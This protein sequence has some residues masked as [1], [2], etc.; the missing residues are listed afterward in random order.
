MPKLFTDVYQDL[1]YVSGCPSQLF[2]TIFKGNRSSKHF[3]V[4]NAI[5]KLEVLQDIGYVAGLLSQLVRP[6]FKVKEASKGAYPYFDEFSYRAPKNAYLK[7]QRFSCAITHHFFGDLD[8]DVKMEKILRTS[9]KN[10]SMQPVIPHGQSNQFL[11]PNEPRSTHTPFSMIFVCYSTLFTGSS[12]F[13]VREKPKY[14]VDVCQDIGYAVLWLTRQPNPFLRSNEPRAFRRHK[15]QKVLWSFVKT[16]AMQSVGQL[17]KYDLFVRMNRPRTA[18]TSNLIIFVCYGTPFFVI[19][20][21]TSKLPKVFVDIHQDLGYASSWPSRPIQPII[22]SQ[23]NPFSW[24]KF[25]KCQTPHDIKNAKFFCKRPSSY[26]S[27]PV[28]P[29]FKM[30]TKNAKIFCGCSSRP[31]VCRSLALTAIPT[32]FKDLGCATGWTS[33]PVPPIHKVKHPWNCTYLPFRRFSCA[34]VDHLFGQTSPEEQIPPIS[35]I[36]VKTLAMHPAI[37]H[38]Q[39]D[40][41]LKFNRATKHSNVKMPKNFVDVRQDLVYV[42]R[43]PLVTIKSSEMLKNFVDVRQDLGCVTAEHIFGDMD[44]DVKKWKQ[45]MC[46][47]FKI[48]LI[49]PHISFLVNKIPTSKMPKILVD[50]NQDLGYAAC[51]P[52]RAVRTIFKDCDV[53]NANILWTSIKTLDMHPVDSDVKKPKCFVDVRQHLGYVT[54]CPS[55]LMSLT[56]STTHFKGQSSPEALIPPYFNNICVPVGLHNHSDPFSSSTRFRGRTSPKMR[57]PPISTNFVCYRSP[58][59]GDLDSDVKNSKKI[60]GR[61]HTN[62]LVIRILTSKIPKNFV[63]DLQELGYVASCLSHLVPPIFKILTSK[64]PNFFVKVDLHLVYEAVVPHVQSGQFSRSKMPRI[65]AEVLHD[66]RYASS[67][68]SR[69]VRHI[70]K[71]KR[72]LNRPYSPFGQFLCTIAHYFFGYPYYDANNAEN[73]CKRPS[74]P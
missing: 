31:C 42:A 7:F 4:E 15:C 11:N 16:L 21:L 23:S 66:L 62:F 9:V 70:F 26:P 64:I 65:F 28:R 24:S 20:I 2:R 61:P 73:F 57:I 41:F 3:D 46:T 47:F 14:F 56:A 18:Q 52:S 13:H 39:S 17:E 68:L 69:P 36:F 43:W 71:F 6:I 55:R 72:Y 40:H 10:L 37:R 35:M 25:L 67:W 29:I 27:R 33:Q 44:F 48:F 38:D 22:K 53:K 32:H 50:V 1:G 8:S 58:F 60:C 54:V 74:R 59:F 51:C 63:N 34:I 30:P 12:D 19:W 5:K 45:F 49:H